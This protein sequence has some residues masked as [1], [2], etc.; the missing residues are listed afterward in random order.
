MRKRN[1]RRLK[2]TLAFILSFVFMLTLVQG[3]IFANAEVIGSEKVYVKVRLNK[4]DKDYE[5][6][7]LWVWEKDKQGKSYGFIGED[8]D[9]KFAVVETV[10]GAKE[11]GVIVRKSSQGNEW[12]V[13]YTGDITVDLNSGDK[14]VV[15]NYV[16]KIETPKVYEIKNL[17]RNFD[18]VQLN[19][20][21]YRFDGNYRDWD[22]YSWLDKIKNGEGKGYPWTSEDSYGKIATINYENVVDADTRGIGTIIRKPDWS[23][24]DIEVDRFINLAYANNEG[25]INAYLVQGNS[26]IVFREEDAVT[27]PGIL[28]AKIDSL[29]EINF[30]LNG[31]VSKDDMKDKI[32]L[33]ETKSGNIVEIDNVTIL[34]S[35]LGGKITTKTSLDIS[36]GYTL[37][38][39]RFFRKRNYLGKIYGSQD[40]ADIYHYDGKLGAIY[41]NDKTSFVLWA[42]TAIR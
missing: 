36:K 30:A 18:K 33:K 11:L 24:K 10:K 2:T 27:A 34:D 7:N 28:S 38:V 16:N 1:M 21:Y 32:V 13:N 31:K 20:H 37:S 9:G 35:L 29:N 22:D 42:P 15:V 39:A 3:S 40:F 19:L 6:W 8:K 23:G 17:N 4:P 25:V 5:G 26:D 41:S 14:E 12:E